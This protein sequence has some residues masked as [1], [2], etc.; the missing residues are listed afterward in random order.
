MNV[1]IEKERFKINHL[2]FNIRK[3]GKEE[4]IKPKVS[5]RKIIKF[6]VEIDEIENGNQLR[7]ST[8]PK[9]DSLNR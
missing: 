9:A 2:T 7:N 5:R 8:K 4:H 3:V 6:R 1:Y